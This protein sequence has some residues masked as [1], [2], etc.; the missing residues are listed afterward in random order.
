MGT[1]IP[2]ATGQLILGAATTEPTLQKKKK[3]LREVALN[4]Q[5]TAGMHQTRQT[6]STSQN[7]H[8]LALAATT[9][10]D[11]ERRLTSKSTVRQQQCSFE[12]QLLQ[13]VGKT[14]GQTT[15]RS[16]SN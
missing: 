8:S 7:T 6:A 4:S 1:K 14:H 9:H 12:P 16:Q 3:E 2:H 13:R 15:V 10:T 11:G 5:T